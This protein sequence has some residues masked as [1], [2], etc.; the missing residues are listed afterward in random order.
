MV[1]AI[2]SEARSRFTRRIREV[3]IEIREGNA[4]ADAAAE[5]AQ[6]RMKRRTD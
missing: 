2:R 4:N 5:D 6:V 1:E 3:T